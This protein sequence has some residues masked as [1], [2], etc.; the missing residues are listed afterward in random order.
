MGGL[1]RSTASFWRS[2]SR[3]TPS[4]GRSLL[5]SSTSLP[6]GRR[7]LSCATSAPMH[8]S[9]GTQFE[10]LILYLVKEWI[11]QLPRDKCGQEIAFLTNFVQET[12]QQGVP[13]PP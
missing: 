8:A 5:G 11:P 6:S 13:K 4:C 1:P 9:F 3:S 7:L 12:A 2:T 10:K